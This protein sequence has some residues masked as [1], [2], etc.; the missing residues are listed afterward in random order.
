L[1][2]SDGQAMKRMRHG[3]FSMGQP[4]SAARCP[5]DCPPS[6]PHFNFCPEA[7]LLRAANPRNGRSQHGAVGIS[8]FSVCRYLVHHM[9]GA[10]RQTMSAQN[11]PGASSILQDAELQTTQAQLAVPFLD[12]RWR[13]RFS[14]PALFAKGKFR[15][16][17]VERDGLCP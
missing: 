16:C 10:L 8:P 2:Y 12:S 6:Y 1:I 15:H 3:W 4:K 13:A 11:H 17:T 14:T 7:S 5:S 9:H